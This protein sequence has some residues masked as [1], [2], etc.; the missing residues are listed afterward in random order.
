MYPRDAE[1]L[2]GLIESADVAL[3]VA[4]TNGKGLY[5]F[6]AHTCERHAA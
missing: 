6:P 2:G 1:H 5:H 3:Y 4:K